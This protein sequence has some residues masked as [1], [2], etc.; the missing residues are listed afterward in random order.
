VA[1][2]QGQHV[3]LDGHAREK[4]HMTLESHHVTLMAFER[5]YGFKGLKYH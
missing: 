4:H 5:L 2:F 1:T 3:A